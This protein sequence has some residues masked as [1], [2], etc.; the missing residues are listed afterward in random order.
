VK[1]TSTPFDPAAFIDGDEGAVA[2]LEYAMATNDP[3][4]IAKAIGDV[5]RARGMTKI[6]KGSGLSRE[7][8]YKA[9]SGDGN[10]EFSTLLRV[11]EAMGLRLSVTVA[12]P[13]PRVPIKKKKTAA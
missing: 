9:L 13:S 4:F 12:A 6:A 2:Y 10:P 11:V 8:L 1:T 3:Q 5:A 7:S